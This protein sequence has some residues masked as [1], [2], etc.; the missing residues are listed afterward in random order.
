[1]ES[2][3]SA[4][5]EDNDYNHTSKTPPLYFDSEDDSDEDYEDDATEITCFRITV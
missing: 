3:D 5:E 2:K 4:E 1:M